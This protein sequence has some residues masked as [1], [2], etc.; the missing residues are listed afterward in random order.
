MGAPAAA[1]DGDGAFDGFSV[2]TIEG[3]GE[4]FSIGV[5]T[6]V[7]AWAIGL[8]GHWLCPRPRVKT[9]LSGKTTV[10]FIHNNRNG[11]QHR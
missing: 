3:T 8:T 5:W 7:A 4:G 2:G 9:A 10:S 1:G 6:M 11:G